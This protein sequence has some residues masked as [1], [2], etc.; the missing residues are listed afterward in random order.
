MEEEKAVLVGLDFSDEYTQLCYFTE[1]GELISVSL[2]KDSTKYRIPSVLAAFAGNSDWM[3]GEDAAGLAETPTCKKITGLASIACR[4]DNTPVFDQDYPADIILERFFRRLLFAF[5]A[6]TGVTKISGMV[7]TSE[8]INDNF[9][10]NV[11]SA[12]DTL[13]VRDNSLKMVTHLESFMYYVVSQ[14][15]DIWINDVGLFDFGRDLFTFYRLSFGRRSIPI[16][17]VAEK[18]DISKKI[19]FSMLDPDEADRLQ[20]VFETTANSLLF[21]QIISGL[22]FTGE[23]FESAWADD[24]LKKLCNGR[25]IFRGQ[26]LYVKGAGYAASLLY[27]KDESPY[28]FVND[29]V[30]KSSISVRVMKDG[31]YSELELAKIGQRCEDAGAE[32]EIIM[33]RTNELDFIVHNVLKK[34]FICA[35]MTLDT[36]VL[37]DD[38]TTRLN[39]RLRFP[40][41]DTCVI[42]VR[43]A[44]F[45]EIYKTNHKIWEQVLKI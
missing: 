13:G 10:K 4:D 44:G 26:N 8:K 43:D 33:D 30:L 28:F 36:L 21:K 20:Y 2:S 39:V 17:V 22:Y 38:R 37:R 1:A 18:Q 32:I 6:K 5:K 25:R 27:G 24:I 3:Y 41:R 7:V 31:E 45:G 40:D 23:G 29:E 15:K 42:T 16:T 9:R 12:L 35:I 34:D 11:R 19:N 14:N